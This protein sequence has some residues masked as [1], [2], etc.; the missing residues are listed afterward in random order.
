MTVIEITVPTPDGDCTASLHTPVGTGAGGRSSWP[1]V[2]LYPDAGGPRAVLRDMADRLASSGYAVLLPDVYYRTPGWAPFDV[3]TVFGDPD[4][5][6]R[7]MG[8]VRSVTAEMYRSDVDAFLDVLSTRAEVAGEKIGTTGYCMGGRA[9]MI[10][11]AHRPDRIAATASFHG[12][13]LGAEGDPDA[14]YRRAGDIRSTVYVAGATND[15]SFTDADR[16]RLETALTEAGVAHT[17]ETYPAAHGF[18]VPDNP[19]FDDAAAERHWT[20]LTSLYAEALPR[21]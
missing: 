2:I 12:G 19:T 4:E 5:R 16:E 20:A 18:S 21:P 8:M 10:V 9:S 3:A 14:P 17:V 1:A 6:A 7:L 15:D 11:A 13:G